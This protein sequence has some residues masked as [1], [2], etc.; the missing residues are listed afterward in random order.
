MKIVEIRNT[1]RQTLLGEKISL[2]NTR[3][4]RLRGLLGRPEPKPGE[5]LLIQPCSGVHMMGMKY[6]LDVAFL[7]PDGSV[8]ATYHA[9]KPGKKSKWHRAAKQALEVRA[10]TLEQTGTQPGD[11]LSV[12]HVG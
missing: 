9:L 10:G 4:T 5:G 12:S 1:T 8:V 2:A 3:W 6:P 11:R 7:G